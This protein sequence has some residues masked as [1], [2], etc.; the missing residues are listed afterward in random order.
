[1][2]P[3]RSRRL[4]QLIPHR[5]TEAPL[6]AGESVGG[7]ASP[8]SGRNRHRAS[9]R[10]TLLGFA[11]IPGTSSW[12]PSAREFPRPIGQRVRLVRSTSA[13]AI[14]PALGGLERHCPRRTALGF[15]VAPAFADSLDL[16]A[17]NL[18]PVP[19]ELPDEIAV[20]L[21]DWLAAPWR[22]LSRRQPPPGCARWSLAMASWAC[23]SARSRAGRGL[24][25]K[26]RGRHPG[27]LALAE[28]WGLRPS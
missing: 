9:A 17:R 20:V 3:M 13:V 12:A 1:M 15:A 18:L 11:G 8:G 25:T 27:K 4:S 24:L 6:A 2:A 26:L 16:P 7:S 21:R 19:R 14:V 5:R 10:A 28:R 23:W 22:S